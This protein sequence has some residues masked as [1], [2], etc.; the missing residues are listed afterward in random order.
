MKCQINTVTEKNSKEKFMKQV[1]ITVSTSLSCSQEKAFSYFFDLVHFFKW[2]NDPGSFEAK[3][4]NKYQF[5][6]VGYKQQMVAG[7]GVVKFN[8]EVT[9]VARNRYVRG[10]IS[11]FFNGTFSWEFMAEKNGCR[12]VKEINI[13]GN[14]WLKQLLIKT[15]VKAGDIKHCDKAFRKLKNIIDNK[16]CVSDAQLISA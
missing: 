15:I 1:K 10:V 16:S 5:Q 11:G 9:E 13:K 4:L 8:S 3:S 2:Y 6:N 14:N 7:G 12:I